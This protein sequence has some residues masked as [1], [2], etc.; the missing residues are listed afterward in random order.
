MYN[1][2]TQHHDNILQT[3]L[4]HILVVFY[5]RVYVYIYLFMGILYGQRMRA[6]ELLLQMSSNRVIR[7][8]ICAQS[9][10]QTLTFGIMSSSVFQV[11]YVGV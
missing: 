5:I 4:I 1:F 6:F 8:L 9:H 11:F 3:L 10:I 2:I 7:D